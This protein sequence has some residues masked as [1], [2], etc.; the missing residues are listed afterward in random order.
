MRNRSRQS[1][2]FRT[3][4]LLLGFVLSGL[5]TG[6]SKY[7][8]RTAQ[9]SAY[10]LVYPDYKFVTIP[11]NIAPLNF[12]IREEGEDFRF[13]IYG[14][15]DTIEISGTPRIC[16]SEE[17]WHRLLNSHKGDSLQLSVSV[18]RDK[19]WNQYQTF[20]I[21]VAPDSIDEY[22]S[23]RLIEPGYEVWNDLQLCERN[24]TGFEE[25]VFADNK[26]FDKNCMNCHTYAN[27]NPE[28]S[29][30][31]LRGDKGGTILNRKG[32]LTKI[33]T[34]G[35]NNAPPGVYG[36]FHPG[37]RYIVFSNNTIIPAFHVNPKK[38]LEVYDNS[39]DLTILDLEKME[40]ISS[41]LIQGDQAYET[42]P[43]F[44]DSGER[45]L[46]C[47][48][49]AITLPDSIRQLRYDLCSIDFHPV[50]GELGTKID[51]L[52]CF[53][54][55]QKS[56]SHPRI[57]PDGRYLLYTLADY[58][59]F[60]IWHPEADLELLDLKTGIRDALPGVNDDFSDSYHSWSSNSRWFVFASKRGD[61]VFGKPYFA[62]V[63]AAGKTHKPFLLPQKDPDH[64]ELCFKS[65]NIP[66]LA[67]G[68]L[69]ISPREIERLYQHGTT[70][71]V[72]SKK[73]AYEP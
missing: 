63:D 46:F 65:Y 16:F 64:Y 23:Y 71:R 41:G 13:R 15:G 37:G 18:W 30:F 73:Q 5:W 32:Q 27:Q 47:R 36:A 24:I 10:P 69:N 49:P 59:T 70:C 12:K 58:G 20:S 6:C 66:E 68:K 33:D 11:V 26:L 55:E 31:H 57:S 56:V 9:L 1:E 17:K 35:D 72:T 54:Q 14:P 62:Y 43:V 52:V 25:R 45:I 28:L 34:R 19:V 48:A 42:F 8:G 61:G 53:S 2:P 60:P 40:L 3:L 50:S 39:S 22:L 51:T 4:G 44:D 29:F 21:Y 7:E 67:T 38:R